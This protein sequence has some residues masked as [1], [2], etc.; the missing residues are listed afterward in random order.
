MAWADCS[1]PVETALKAWDQRYLTLQSQAPL[2]KVSHPEWVKKKLAHMVKVD[3]EMRDF[4]GTPSKQGWNEKAAQCFFKGFAPRWQR[5]DETNT[6]ELKKILERHHWFYRTKW[7]AKADREGWLL[8]QHADR[9]RAFQIRM[10]K[11]LRMLYRTGETLPRHYAYLHDRVAAA[12]SYPHL[13]TK[14]RFGTQGT[15]VGKGQWRPLPIHLPRMVDVRRAKMGLEPMAEYVKK[16][17]TI[18]R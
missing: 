15:C 3:Q 13:R 7:G 16:F 2:G 10:R 6:E 8:V 9:D 14:Q 1:E 4:S 12:W 5:V 11:R 18:C 17:K